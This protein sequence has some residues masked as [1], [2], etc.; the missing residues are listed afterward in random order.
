MLCERRSAPGRRWI[1]CSLSFAQL[2]LLTCTCLLL[3]LFVY[4]RQK[5]LIF[6]LVCGSDRLKINKAARHVVPG[7]LPTCHM[8][9]VSV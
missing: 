2:R 3:C 5:E 4:Y 7:L 9:M 8:G 1:G 6:L